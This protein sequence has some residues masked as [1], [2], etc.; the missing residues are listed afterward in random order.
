M[1]FYRYPA[2]DNISGLTARTMKKIPALKTFKTPDCIVTIELLQ[3]LPLIAFVI[4]LIWYLVTPTRIAAMG[5]SATGGILLSAYLWARSLAR[6]VRAQRKLRYTALQVGDEL[7]E[8]ISLKNGSILPILWAEFSDRSN[9]PGYTVTSVRAA[10]PRNTVQWRARAICTRRGI[11]ALGPWELL[12]GDPFG[13]LR[14]RMLYY[15]HQEI[16]VYPPLAELPP[17]LLE[18]SGIQGDQ[19]PLHQ[20]IHAETMDAFSARPYLPGDPL[21][22]I[23]W[24]TTARKDY[25]FVKLFEPQAASSV[26]LV[27]DCDSAVHL[28]EG[29]QS[30]FETMILVLASLASEMLRGQLSVGLFANASE[31]NLVSPQPGQP[32]LW[33]ILHA[34]APLEP[35]P[36]HPLK[37]TLDKVRHLVTARNMIVILTPSLDPGW[38]PYAHRLGGPHI[39]SRAEVI[40]LD[41][42]SFGGAG[43]AEHMLPILASSGITSRVIQRGQIKPLS[44]SY[45]EL[46]RWEFKNLAT[47]RVVARHRPHVA[48]GE[49]GT[50]R[51][52]KWN[53]PE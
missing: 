13:I 51:I 25:P 43:H 24:R 8:E 32:H 26:W 11:F 46:G 10:D 5:V 35:G 53:L 27:P 34:L 48:M 9:I 6:N 22:H 18:H 47:G 17:H 37:E 28:G 30:T 16:L 44:G 42:A 31:Q 2:W 15:Q 45:G 38:L 21:H 40:L 1:L 41:P 7:E 33:H 12:M 4:F 23:H 29:D 49:V 52:G 3:L 20:P 50:T 19:R 14:V 36:G 39:L